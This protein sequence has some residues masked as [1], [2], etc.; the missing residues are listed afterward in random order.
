MPQTVSAAAIASMAISGVVALLTPIVLYLIA[1]RRNRARMVPLLLGAVTFV[2]FAL[3]L[4]R[5]V[6]NLILSNTVI[7]NFI[8]GHWWAYGL[9]GGLMA[10]LF[11]ETGRLCV[12]FFLLRRRY[13]SLGGALSYGIGHGGVEAVLLCTLTMANNIVLS[14]VLNTSGIEGLTALSPTLAQ[15]VGALTSAPASLFLAG[16]LERVIAIAVH[17]ALSVLV[18]MAA[19]GRGPWGLYFLAILFHTAINFPT[20]LYHFKIIQNAWIMEGIFAVITV[21]ICVTVSAIHDKCAQTYTSLLHY[22][23]T[24]F[25]L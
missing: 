10:G 21:V 7:H 25:G 12:F 13:N 22:E 9:Y 24:D 5:M 3:V 20:A 23:P 1:R 19:T 8:A 16:G 11:E 6:G 18:W 2:L 14:V 17:I 4:E 15:S